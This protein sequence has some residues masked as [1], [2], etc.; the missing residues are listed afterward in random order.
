[1]SGV[2]KLTI[3]VVSACC[4]LAGTSHA[5]RILITTRTSAQLSGGLFLDGD[6]VAYDLASA[7]TRTIFSESTTFDGNTN[8]DAIHRLNDGSILLS[9]SGNMRINGIRYQSGDVVHYDPQTGTASLFLDGRDHFGQSANVDAFTIA[10][11]GTLL[12]SMSGNVDING[13]RYSD[14]DIFAYDPGART[15]SLIL[16][17]SAFG[18]GADVNGLAINTNG[19]LLISTDNATTLGGIGFEDY[20]IVEYDVL[21]DL[22]TIFFDGSQIIVGGT[23]DSDVWGISLP[24]PNTGVLVLLGLAAIAVHRRMGR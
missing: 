10:D 23:D 22:A 6:I 24:E 21:G 1:M 17:E 3:A 20:D 8:L 19:N 18:G 15:A 11:D 12:L 16:D 7:A 13:T 4:C 2:L 5:D 9:A 14:G